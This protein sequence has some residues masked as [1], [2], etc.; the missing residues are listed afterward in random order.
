MTSSCNAQDTTRLKDYVAEAKRLN[1]LGGDWDRRNRLKVYE[2]YYL[3]AIRDLKGVST[4]A[5]LVT[6][7]CC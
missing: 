3:L 2:A 5:C 4:A 6:K 7:R 1:E